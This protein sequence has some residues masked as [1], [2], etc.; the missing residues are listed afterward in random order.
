MTTNVI[1]VGEADFQSQVLEASKT[2]PVVVDFWASWCGPCR[3]LSPILEKAAAEG[4][5]SWTLA[6]VDVDANQRLAQAFQV[7]SIPTVIA[8]KDGRPVNMFT[9]AL[10]ESQVRQFLATL[11]APPVDDRVLAAEALID[12]GDLAGAE[13]ALTSI[14]ATEPTNTEAAVSLASLM[15]ESGRH[16]DALDVLGRQ[17][18]T[19][20]VRQMMAAARL[21]GAGEVD[22]NDPAAALPRLLAAVEEGGDG[23]EKARLTM[24]DLFDLLGPDHELTREYRRRLASALF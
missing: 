21:L 6:K 14:L 4:A 16:D 9:G 18:P 8:F 13:T 12:S 5:G 20:E 19:D 3:T 10:P 11:V 1:D 15:I 23:R 24:I 2:V 7:Q 22:L 17:A